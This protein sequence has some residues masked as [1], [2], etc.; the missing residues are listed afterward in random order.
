MQGTEWRLETH[1]VLE[2]KGE[3]S[4]RNLAPVSL[5]HWR[6]IDRPPLVVE[7]WDI[8]AVMATHETYETSILSSGLVCHVQTHNCVFPVRGSKLVLR[9]EQP[10]VL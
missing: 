8:R 2:L 6:R 4:L 5:S 7:T 1:E 3:A 10:S 9:E